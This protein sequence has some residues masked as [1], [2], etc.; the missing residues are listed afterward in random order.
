MR[1][2]P[3]YSLKVLDNLF[4]PRSVCLVGASHSEDKLG[5]V[6]LKNLLGKRDLKIYPVNPVYDS[7]MGVPALREISALPGADLAIIIRPAPEVSGI[8]KELK[9]KTRFAIIVSAGFSEAG[10]D[11]LQQEVKKTAAS[12]GIQI[13][14]PNCMGIYNT[15]S[16]LDTFILPS[17]RVPRPKRGNIGFTTQSGAVLSL[18]FEY[19]HA[20]GTGISAA[21]H[22]GNAAGL[23]ECD[24]YSY[25]AGDKNTKAV[26][27]YLESIRD[28]RRFLESAGKL[29]AEGKPLL[30]LKAGK[31]HAGQSAAFSHTGRLAGSYGVFSSVLRQ[32]G[33][34]EA[35][36]LEELADG[37]RGLS[38]SKAN[39][40]KA[41]GRKILVLTNGGGA[42]V[43][44]ADEF[45][46]RGIELPPLPA[47]S[48]RLL[49]EKLPDFYG[50]GNP[51]DLTAQVR[52]E[53]YGIVLDELHPHYDGFL[54]IALSAVR[55]VTE[56]LAGILAAF[57]LHTVKPV[58]L[59][60]GTDPVAG[61]IAAGAEAAGIPVFSTP[62]RA[63]K[64]LG[65]LL[66]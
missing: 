43:L 41:A 58:V 46:R 42:G 62:E 18:I 45:A 36:D 14:G 21:A 52:D 38:V 60:I 57:S 64:V 37:A 6:V 22:Y 50:F 17:D 2:R 24:F 56:G 8:L 4:A 40:L 25:F 15:G 61:T 27:S 3:S 35:M 23:D 10:H 59:H 20:S 28:G 44:A 63:A 48:E 39:P 12:A 26:I 30:V 1:T 49:R 66:G 51:F 47:E 53:D 16:G 19:F 34:T 32:F 29:A 5:G 33:I 65:V 55:G 31:G 9:G 11:D 13:L 54:I 7:L